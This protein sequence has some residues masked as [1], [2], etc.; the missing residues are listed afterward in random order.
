MTPASTLALSEFESPRAEGSLWD[1]PGNYR[2]RCAPDCQLLRIDLGGVRMAQAVEV[3]ADSNDRYELVF[4]RS[5]APVG[6]VAWGSEG[7]SGM[8]V[9]RRTSR[10]RWPPA[11]TA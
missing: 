7:P 11:T 6:R 3:S 8:H 9:V 2:F 1:A 10:R 5:G 4:Y